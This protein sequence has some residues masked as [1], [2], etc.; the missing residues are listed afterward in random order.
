M[1]TSTG[2]TAFWGRADL[3]GQHQRPCLATVVYYGFHPNGGSEKRHSISRAMPPSRLEP[4]LVTKDINYTPEAC[5]G[6]RE[7]VI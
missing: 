7:M 1:Q 6:F 4:E 3:F 5:K 2:E